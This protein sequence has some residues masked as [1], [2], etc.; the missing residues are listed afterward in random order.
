MPLDITG[1]RA[2]LAWARHHFEIVDGEIRAWLK[3]NPHELVFERNE[4][5]TKYWLRVR[6]IGDTPDFQKWGLIIGDCVTNLRDA[7]DHFIFAVA[8][9][10]TSPNP[11]KRDR[12]AFVIR[13]RREDFTRDSRTRLASVPDPVRDSVLSFQPF[14]RRSNPKIP[15]LLGVLAELANGN[16]HKVLTFVLTTPSVI[17]VKLVSRGWNRPRPTLDMYKGD[18]Q[19]GTV[20]CLF[21]VP[22]P[23]PHIQLEPDSLIR[24]EV[25]LKHKPA[26]GN[27]AF[28]ADRTNYQGLILDIFR[29]VEFVIETLADLV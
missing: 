29:E 26:E 8:G 25:A 6:R 13:E 28:D 5:Y 21:Q 10:P 24:F 22:E 18:I 11:D 23:D 20:V 15:S 12:A 7:L 9:L 14:N 3:G 2:K 17:D 19:D 16:K 4:Q 1:T 27:T